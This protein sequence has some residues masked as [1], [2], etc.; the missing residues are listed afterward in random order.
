MG[1]R[2]KGLP[3]L[4]GS[5][6][7]VVALAAS[8]GSASASPPAAVTLSPDP[9]VFTADVNAYD[10]EFLTLTTGPRWFV[11]A[12][13]ASASD[14]A[15]WDTQA[16]TCWQGYE[17]L[18]DRI[19]GKASCTFQIGFHPASPGTYTATFT[20]Y[21]CTAWHTDPT[22]GFILCDATD[23]SYSVTLQGTATAP[24]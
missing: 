2:F 11:Y 23:G 21:R 5:L 20:I 13:P 7:S 3:F 8:V 6:L 10:Y 14:A 12:G 19:P 1:T 17:S 24:V 4:I 16:G 15:F 22:Y 18:G 9:V